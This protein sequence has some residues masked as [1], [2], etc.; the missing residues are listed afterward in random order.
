MTRRVTWAY[1]LCAL[2]LAVSYL[3]F[4]AA[5]LVCF[6]GLVLTTLAAMLYG[7][8]AH[9]PRRKLPWLL[10]AGGSLVLAVGTA[11]AV[12]QTDVL[13]SN[14]WPTAVDA[15]SLGGTF[16]LLLLGL[17][18]LSRSGAANR[19][20]ATVID[21]AI[22]TAGAGLLA[23]VFLIDP[24]LSDPSL[25][26][27]Q[28]AIS[29]AYPLCDVML[30][31][32]MVRMVL[33][34][35]R[36]W[37]VALL[38]TSGAVLLVSDVVFSLRRLNGDWGLGSFVDVGWIVFFAAGGLA[39]LHPSMAQLSEPRVIGSTQVKPRRAVLGVASL[40]APGILFAEALDGPVHNGVVIAIGSAALVALSLSRG[41]V[42]ARSVGHTLSRERALR[43]ACE[44]LLSATEVAMVEAVVRRAVGSLLRPGTAH[45]AL[46]RV[47]PGSSPAPT[48]SMRYVASLPEDF[49]RELDGFELALHCPLTVGGV[50]LGELWVA[51]DER[52]L[53][54]LQESARVLAGQAAS[55]LDHIALNREI[56]KRDSEAYFRTL[57][58]NAADVILI[59]GA[60]DRV[61]YASPSATA[62]FGSGVVGRTF[63]QLNPGLHALR[64]PD[65]TTAEVEVTVRDL[66]GE[67][68]VDGRV[69]TIH[70]VTE[71]RR[72]ERE[73]LDRAYLDPLTGLGNRLRFQDAVQTA[74]GAAV[75]IVDIDGFRT[76][77]DTMGQEVGDELLRAF[78]ARLT[79]VS[80]MTATVARLGGDEFGVLVSQ[81]SVAEVE[82][83]AERIVEEF[84]P[85][86]LV[87]GSVVSAVPNI[88]VA[89]TSDAP[90]AAK[91]LGE[92]DVALN[93]AK[94]TPERWRRYESAMHEQAVRRM[95]LR[96]DLDQALVTDAFVLHYQP[97]VD[98]AT[99]RP[100]GFEALVR[101]QHPAL[102]LVPPLE[103]IEIAEECGLIVPLGDW[104]MRHAI[105][106]AVSFRSLYPADSLTM[107]VNVSVRQ[108]RSPGFVQRVLTELAQADLPCGAL[109]VEITESL[110]LGDD[111]HIHADLA[112]LRAAGVRVS[113][114]DFGTGYS[115]LSYLHRV[116]VDALKLDKSFVDTIGS[117]RRQYDL[118]RGIVQLARTL[119]LEVVAEGIETEAH[120]KR[121]A[122]L[123]CGYG[124]GYLFTRPLPYAAA[125]EWLQATSEVSPAA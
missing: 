78:G 22:F 60:D 119:D 11:A 103:F 91:L 37:S 43:K 90:D 68:T 108:F 121:L 44:A 94:G 101:W 80:P 39:A 74:I 113:I 117:S 1:A 84:R 89:M 38:L 15:I 42:A 10:W 98:L 95:R 62:L 116:A 71:R 51:A 20:W 2:V 19:D 21:S 13:H 105:A 29:I 18:L 75:L 115:S 4:P 85:P 9:R 7:I 59:V 5:G 6:A 54:T 79:S 86:F 57:V 70:D 67:P 8:R 114:D 120:R 31:A 41:G 124:Q 83:L 104:V 27:A 52:A 35:R 97:I 58:L 96:T 45:R 63:P 17:L 123:H 72:L 40:V 34:A 56:I 30:L 16:P 118:V 23:W 73:L 64:R 47:A 61:T 81:A 87:G 111:E 14:A 65:G 55:M 50:Q 109:T 69:L 77:N 82:D 66:T 33:E 24:G 3:L 76:V 125:V 32:I 49:A 106:A 107:S 26:V 12:V 48:M 102:G 110:L 88:G 25:N 112:A 122:D 36:S 99:G 46:L 100:H 93:S 92:A 53:V 28:K